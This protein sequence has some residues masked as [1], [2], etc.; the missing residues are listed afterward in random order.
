[1]KNSSRKKKVAFCLRGAVSKR[2]MFSRKNTLYSNDKYCDYVKC[3]NSIFKYI[4]E[5][6]PHYEI[7]F[8]CHCWNIDLKD[9]LKSLYYPKNILVEDNNKYAEEVRTHF[10]KYEIMIDDSTNTL[11]KKIRSAEKMK[12]CY[13][14]IVGEKE[15]QESK[16]TVRKNNKVLGCFD[17]NSINELLEK[18]INPFN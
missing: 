4:V 7:D 8:F 17:Y 11:N 5:Q 10:K 16:V 13:I 1:M 14:F 12:Y 2:I 15:E 9:S 3:R 6:N 18:E